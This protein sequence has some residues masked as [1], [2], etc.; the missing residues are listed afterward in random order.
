MNSLYPLLAVLAASLAMRGIVYF[1]Y[2]DS[3]PVMRRLR[4]LPR[5]ND[6]PETYYRPLDNWLAPL[7]FVWTWLD[8]VAAVMAAALADSAVG[9]ALVTLWSGGR[10]RALQEFGHNA[11]HFALCPSHAWQWWLS[12]IF[13]QF[14]VFKR[15]MHSRHKTHGDHHRKPNHPELDPN[16]ARVFAGGYL[17]GLSDAAF[18][19][20]LLYPLWPAGFWNNLSTMTRNSLLNHSKTTAL[21]R[22][23][24]LLATGALL[25]WVGGW[26]GVAFGWLLPLFTSYPVFAWV[27]LL[28]EHR[29]FMPGFPQE[30]LE[31][32]YLMGRPTDY[33]GVSGW[34]VRVFIAPTSDAYHLV[35]S[36][37][38]GVRWN[39]LPAI[40]RHL[41]IHDPRY[42]EHASEGLLRCRGNAPSALSELRERLVAPPLAGRLS[43]QGIH[44]D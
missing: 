12:D 2:R 38:P 31:L 43:T 1:Y 9:W 41:K 25:Y 34:L 33:F 4:L 19:A 20:R 32:E 7:P 27:S 37:Y 13:Y 11:V 36:L 8:I 30:R 22:C 29:W 42:T 16:R 35:H 21:A 18:L 23:A 39:Y 44:H 26:A 5:I 10:M 28:A 24:T 17:A 15:D 40:D 14:P 3:G 6:N